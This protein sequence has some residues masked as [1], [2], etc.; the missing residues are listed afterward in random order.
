MVNVLLLYKLNL[1]RG[2]RKSLSQ[3][4][5]YGMY[6]LIGTHKLTGNDENLKLS[7]KIK[8]TFHK[9]FM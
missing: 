8:Q 3:R 1:V 2:W 6:L 5:L 9:F 4:Q 7:I